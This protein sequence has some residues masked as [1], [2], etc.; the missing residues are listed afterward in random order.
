MALIRKRKAAEPQPASSRE[1]YAG[2]MSG[3]SLDG[4]DAVIVDFAPPSGAPC[5]TLG[6]A[7]I[8]Y[9]TM[10]RDELLALQLP[11][12]N[13][14]AR[15]GSVAN[16]L[17]ELYADAIAR[18]L[19]AAE[20]EA[21]DVVAAGV[22]GQT[23]RHRPERGFTLQLNNAARV[24]ER[25]NVT[26][27]AD[28]RTRDVAAGGQGAPLVPAFH[29]ALF[30]RPDR[31]RVIV[32]VGGIAN[33]TDLPPGGPIRGFDTG[34]GNVL[35]DLWCASKRGDPFDAQGAWAATGTVDPT[36]LAALLDEPFFR[37]AP[38]KSTH[39]DTFTP[40]WLE[41][42]IK[43]AKWKGDAEDVQA[44]LVALTARTIADA[45][46]ALAPDSAKV[47]VCG[48]GANNATL[49]RALGTELAPREVKSTADEGVPVEHVEALAFAWLARETL[50]GRPGNLPAVTGAKGPRVLGAIYPK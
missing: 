41:Q 16:V 40:Q 14:L 8:A 6:D 45:V 33:I 27:V 23:L 28:F 12:A 11:G 46:R 17:A 34:P 5:E 1:L 26:V 20:L 24:A 35:S 4:V 43:A 18:A 42:K 37:A 47:L 49:M 19:A 10:V 31:H 15:A 9:P 38:P 36:L 21:D 30:G 39:R 22:H 29:A 13:E 3:T 32:N 44:T 25:A 7:H 2:V 50:A 48:G